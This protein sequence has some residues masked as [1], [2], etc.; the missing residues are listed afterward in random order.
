MADAGY[1]MGALETCRSALD[2]KAGPVGA[3]G[4]GFENQHVD[5]A[6]FGELDAA[7]GLASAIANL[8]GVAKQQF[9]GAEQLLRGVSAALDAVRTSVEEIERTNADSLRV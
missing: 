8:D 6:I 4:D 2:G 7:A 9:D 3:I 1:N 5:A